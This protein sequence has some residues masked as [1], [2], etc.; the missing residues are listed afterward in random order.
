MNSIGKTQVSLYLDNDILNWFRNREN[1]AD[2]GNSQTIINNALREHLLHHSNLSEKEEKKAVYEVLLDVIIPEKPHRKKRI[3]L[4]SLL[5]LS[6][7][8][9]L[10]ILLIIF[11]FG[12]YLGVID[13]FGIKSYI[14]Y[15]LFYLVLLVK[16]YWNIIKEFKSD[17]ERSRI[18]LMNIFQNKSN[19][20]TDKLINLKRIAKQKT[21][22]SVEQDIDVLIKRIE[23]HARYINGI[24]PILS[25]MFV[26]YVLFFWGDIAKQNLDNKGLLYGTVKGGSGLVTI[27]I[28]GLNAYFGWVIRNRLKNFNNALYI[29]KKAQNNTEEKSNA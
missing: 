24:V 9:T 22:K 4:R 28:F 27:G 5:T 16:Y 12:F 3:N 2:S 6:E 10:G 13:N 1:T 25:L 29:L 17:R 8:Q 23:G 18:D 11:Y 15:W 7:Q 19:L 14:L 21:L 26:S 20:L